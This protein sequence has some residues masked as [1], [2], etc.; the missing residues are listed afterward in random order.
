MKPVIRPSWVA[1]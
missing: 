1:C